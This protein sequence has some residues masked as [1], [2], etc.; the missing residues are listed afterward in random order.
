MINRHGIA[1]KLFIA[2]LGIAGV[3]LATGL[4]GWLILRD[5][6]N[7]QS[8]IVD[9]AMPALDEVREAA[10]TSARLISRVPALTNATNQERR[11]VEEKALI[12]EAEAFWNLIGRIRT[13]DFD[14]RRVESLSETAE[15][16]LRNLT[17]QGELVKRR[18]ELVNRANE[19][20]DDAVDAA[21]DLSDLSETL[22][23][24]AAAGTTA[25][26]SNLYGLVEEEDNNDIALQALDRLVERDVFLLERM[27]ELR[28]RS[29][30][31]G[32]LLNQLTRVQSTR[33]IDRIARQYRENIGILERRVAG[34]S[35]PIRAGL[36][37]DLLARLFAVDKSAEEPV[38][39]IWRKVL[40]T[41]KHVEGLAA[42]NR[43]L[44]GTLSG[45]VRELVDEARNLSSASAQEADRAVRSGLIVLV[46]QVGAAF[47]IAG[48]ILWLYV[49]RNITR[50]LYLLAGAMKDLARGNM[51]VTVDS[52]GHDELS[53]MARTVDVFRDQAIVK[54]RLEQERERTEQELRKH[55]DALEELVAER[56]QQLRDTNDQLEQAVAD[57]IAARDRA[58]A[59]SRSKSEFLA[60][61][62]HEIRTPMNG[63][64]GMLRILATSELS[65]DQ[66]G[67][68]SIIQS[69][70]QT[71]LGILNDILDYSKI[72][73]GEVQLEP[74]TF[75]LRHLIEDIAVL[76]RFRTEAKGVSLDICIA[77]DVPAV[78]VGDSGKVSQI[79]INLL[80]NAAKFTDT[81]AIN[82]DV[83]RGL[84]MI[85]FDVTDSGIGIEE[86]SVGRL[87]EPFVQDAND[88]LHKR[89]GT[90]L[91]LAISKRLVD[92]M[93]GR[94]GASKRPG[95]GSR[96][97]FEVPLAA[98][99][100]SKIH[101]AIED[102]PV[103]DDVIGSRTILVVEDNEVNAIVAEGFLERMGHTVT[104][105]RSGEEAIEAVSSTVFDAVLMD[106]SLPGMDG[107][108]TTR[109]IRELSDPLA[110]KV[111][112]IAMS[113]H[114][115]A[116]EINEHLAAGMDLFV[117][118]PVSP[119]RLSDALRI[120]LRDSG[121]I[122]IAPI[123]RATSGER[124]QVLNSAI[125]E[126]DYSILGYDKTVR[127]IDAFKQEAQ[128]KAEA[129]AEAVSANK[130]RELAA[131]SH[132]LKSAAGQ[133]GLPGLETA[134]LEFETAA[135]KHSLDGVG[136]SADDLLT[137][138]AE[139]EAALD[140][141]W[142]RIAVPSN[143]LENGQMSLA[144]KR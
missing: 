9:S 34:I 108:E 74:V 12:A 94:I 50:R 119:E 23:A 75:D 138:V 104:V 38:F 56:T 11:E 93:E 81:G 98:G 77:N 27:F 110:R 7:A 99:D 91:G 45:F 143:E 62:S 55:R 134:C 19:M 61:M 126:Q 24:N 107:L 87:F 60:S 131:L 121:S 8:T 102:L 33:E 82:L 132:S 5:V 53:E 28:L 36:A 70:S 123:R 42:I 35:D 78:L 92:A 26:I 63:V 86:E 1:G 15:H 116:S 133:L 109:R 142:S 4:V 72:E 112:V 22:V 29:S 49:Q 96:F 144:A 103:Q 40:I 17:R 125:L 67:Y 139:S 117:G 136:T 20:T 57:H 58:E 137:L 89:G 135:R 3:S 51:S 128:A 130:W 113:A 111:P 100:P 95:G 140:D 80:G 52:S 64:L 88:T 84:G 79:L 16:L 2:F 124:C 68:L 118:K 21:T 66:R 48:L 47:A 54:Q 30:Q 83:V 106:V 31:T 46:I 65:S 32:L 122:A 37:R 69:S 43:N 39:Q 115:F 41:N 97:W 13:R 90:G 120:V 101:K 71:L 14:T 114:V 129:M 85:R 6:S 59:A 105:V 127:I 10:E 25:V 141:L 44:S 18:I 73:A 76:M